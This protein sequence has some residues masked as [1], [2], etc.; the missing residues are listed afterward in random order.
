MAEPTQARRVFFDRYRRWIV[1]AIGFLVF[2]P[3]LLSP[4][5]LDDYV[6]KAMARGTFPSPR[7]PFDL[8]NFVTDGD[9]TLLIDRGVLP[10]W[11]HPH[12]TIRFFRPLSSLL[13]WLDFRISDHPLLHHAHSFLW[14]ALAVFGARALYK[15][16][17]SPRAAA[18]ATAIFA[19]APC[20]AI[21]LS[22]LANR[23]VLVSLAFGTFAMGAL[24]RYRANGKMRDF[25]VALVLFAFAMLA[26]EY[27]LA[28][29]GYV[30]ALEVLAP[31]PT[32][33]RRVMAI[34]TFA[35]PALATVVLR[36]K[37]GFGNSGSGFYRDPFSQTHA[38]FAGAPRRMAR[39]VVD[40]WLSSDSEWV[41][42][43][44]P[45]AVAAFVIVVGVLVAIPI[46]RA[47]RSEDAAMRKLG[48]AL[49]A[50]SFIALLPM[51]AVLP[52]PR[53][54]GVAVLGMAPVI[55]VALDHAW[56]PSK[57]G[58]AVRGDF[59]SVLAVL[60][61]FFHLVHGPVTSFLSTRFF[62]ET[63][64][65]FVERTAWLR[66]RVD[67][68][69]LEAKIVVARAG[70]QTVLFAPFALDVDGRLPERWWVL[71]LV[72]HALILRR[73]DRSI[74]LIVP[75]GRGYF[76]TGPDD[77]F[78]SEDRPLHAGDVVRVPGLTARVIEGG[79]SGP[80]RVRFDFDQKLESLVWIADGKEGWR[81]TP[82]PQVGFGMPLDP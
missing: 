53:L 76:P 35:L 10:W 82:P 39:L 1:V 13:R 42:E 72:P 40:A 34:E 19:L 41:M 49:V 63:S 12:L 51:V 37:L 75:K 8:Y 66:E 47:F 23:E 54:L 68:K 27:A 29:G 20:H 6:H 2:L 24:V 61:G 3:G 70:W 62:H 16:W 59:A 7:S 52:S 73:S 71:S 4:Y 80:G 60:L 79:E 26:G 15:Q 18:I 77:L 57:P 45:Y 38:F 21:P 31:A 67:Q 32:L 64:T 46:R 78:R 33:K 56:F 55:G 69:P 74:D 28:F 44:K 81:D 36:A 50:G 17:I 22:W 65:N 30:V 9:R 14:W 48:R 11:T 25:A 43:A 58:D 5:W